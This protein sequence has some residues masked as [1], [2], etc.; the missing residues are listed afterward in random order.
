MVHVVGLK[1]SDSSISSVI[2]WLAWVVVAM[3]TGSGMF[4]GVLLAGDAIVVGRAITDN[5]FII[6]CCRPPSCCTSYSL[7]DGSSICN[8]YILKK[9][10]KHYCS[11]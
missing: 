5:S 1:L 6:F 2:C 4:T 11:H 7:V 9:F 8:N 10:L 3:G